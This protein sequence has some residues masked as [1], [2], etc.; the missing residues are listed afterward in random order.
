MSAKKPLYPQGQDGQAVAGLKERKKLGCLAKFLI[1][2]A[3]TV[4][5]LAAVTVTG[6]LVGNHL[7]K[8]NFGVSLF[9]IFGCMSDL[10]KAEREDIVTNP[11]SQSD[12]AG[13][14]VALDSSLFLKDGTVDKE[15]LDGLTGAAD[16]GNVSDAATSILSRESFSAE[17]LAAYDAVN[18]EG[19]P[20]A[21]TDRQLAAFLNAYIVESGMLDEAAGD[22]SG[23]LG[24]SKLSDVLS[25]EQTILQSGK[26]MSAEDKAAYSATDGGVYLTVTFSFDIKSTMKS[27]MEN[28]GAGGFVWIVNMLLPEA[29]YLSATFDLT[30]ASYGVKF[31][32]NGMSRIPCE[33]NY[34][35]EEMQAKYGDDVSGYD[36]LCIIIE[37][38]SGMDV[39]ESLSSGMGGLTSFLCK[40]GGSDDG[41]FCFADM[42]DLDSVKKSAAGGNEFSL[43]TMEFITENINS[44]TGGNAAKD[45]VIA[46]IQALVCTDY[47]D[48]YDAPDRVDLY[49]E[50]ADALRAALEECG[51]ASITDVRTQSDIDK[52]AAAYPGLAYDEPGAPVGDTATNVYNDA[53]IDA[54][55]DAYGVDMTEYENGD[56]GAPVGRYGF[57]DL[58]SLAGTDGTGLTDGQRTLAARIA[59]AYAEGASSG[60]V[61]EFGITEKMFGAALRE[62]SHM[63]DGAADIS[64]RSVDFFESDGK[65]YADLVFTLDSSGLISDSVVNGMLPEYIS[66]GVRAEITVGSA[67]R[68]SAKMISFNGLTESGG[69]AGIE[70][71][72][73]S[74]FTDSLKAVLPSVDF[75]G[76]L[77]SVTEGLNGIADNIS[78][79]FPG[80]AF[81]TE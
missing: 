69:V 68:E 66:I 65:T 2:L 31:D 73:C 30:D 5:I 47:D 20:A 75:D 51:F 24:D 3:I 52:L 58:M 12:E 45:D 7:L 70:E 9:D 39:N 43:N 78:Q 11:Y 44:A 18:G 25:V 55:S 67:S 41:T 16:G 81:V 36:R 10:K 21:M 76:I 13:F 33:M 62:L 8:S 40:G 56:S 80:A 53:F 14:Y 29:A 22:L 79:Y 46:I 63:Y 37:S 74:E 48:A 27:V 71:L 54:F 72:T 1:S 15:Y 19:T 42:I 61:P 28:A 23:V 57:D 38:F 4:A 77:S 6:L 32:V 26:D 50:D 34:I 49:A 64:L 35:T 60:K 17:K 59:A